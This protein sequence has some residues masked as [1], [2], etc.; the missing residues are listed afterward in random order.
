MSSMVAHFYPIYLIGLFS[1]SPLFCWMLSSVWNVSSPSFIA[2]NMRL[3]KVFHLKMSLKNLVYNNKLLLQVVFLLLNLNY[4][5]KSYFSTNCC[6]II[7]KTK[8][9]KT[10]S[11]TQAFKFYIQ[12]HFSASFLFAWCSLFHNHIVKLLL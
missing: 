7:F 10:P 4:L 1:Y 6:K 2:F 9:G 11:V 5:H 3:D 8:T 12:I